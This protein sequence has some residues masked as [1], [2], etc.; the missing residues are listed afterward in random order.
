MEL[1]QRRASHRHCR[2]PPLS[3]T[4]PWPGSSC[5]SRTPGV[6]SC[7][8][9]APTSNATR[10][11]R[12]KADASAEPSPQDQ[13]PEDASDSGRTVP[14]RPPAPVGGT[15]LP[16]L[17]SRPPHLSSPR[18]RD[19]RD[20]LHYTARTHRR[21]PRP[22]P[23]DP[24]PVSALRA[25]S[26]HPRLR[27]APRAAVRPRGK[28]DVSARDPRPAS[29]RL[30]APSSPTGGAQVGLPSRRA[31]PAAGSPRLPR[32]SSR[33]VARGPRKGSTYPFIPRSSCSQ[34]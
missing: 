17:R 16:R 29:T 2:F 7:A 3:R 32:R 11:K 19:A 24:S 1:R 20:R 8:T 25:A 27:S 13:A 14:R 28:A 22:P 12:K 23:Q 34:R 31:A 15:D 9:T 26:G 21:H 4:G 33:A 30:W 18:K 10:G 5:R 6:I